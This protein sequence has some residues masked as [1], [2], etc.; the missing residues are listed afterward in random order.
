[1]KLR[2]KGKIYKVIE[3]TQPSDISIVKEQAKVIN[4]KG[5]EFTF[6]HSI[7]G[8]YLYDDKGNR[9]AET[10]SIKWS[11]DNGRFNTI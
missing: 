4:S 2:F 1:M 9:V 8:Y 11:D 10:L 7:T 6:I 5:I 3:F